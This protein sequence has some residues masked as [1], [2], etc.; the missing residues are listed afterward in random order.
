MGVMSG[1]LDLVQRC[2]AGAHVRDGALYFDPRLPAWLDGLSFSG[3]FR[4]TPIEVTL[5]RD[6]LTLAVH[7]EGASRPIGV[8]IPGDVRELRPASRRCSS[9]PEASGRRAAGRDD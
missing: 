7:P 5:T 6:R 4:D 8:A 2:Y 1:T 3:Q 9:S